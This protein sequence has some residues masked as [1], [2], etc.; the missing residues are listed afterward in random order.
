MI[1]KKRGSWTYAQKRAIVEESLKMGASYNRVTQ[2]HGLGSTTLKK[3]QSLYNKGRL[4]SDESAIK[5]K[6][7]AEHAARAAKKAVTQKSPAIPPS[8]FVP[9]E[10]ITAALFSRGDTKFLVELYKTHIEEGMETEE[11]L[12]FIINSVRWGVQYEM[13]AN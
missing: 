8:G 12:E 10:K 2:K 9:M 4:T 11:A 5:A 3:W 13:E 7:E 6:V 1:R